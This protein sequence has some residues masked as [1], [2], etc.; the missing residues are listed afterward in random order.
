MEADWFKPF[1]GQTGTLRPREGE[2]VPKVT[3]EL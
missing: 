3:C 1:R 2:G